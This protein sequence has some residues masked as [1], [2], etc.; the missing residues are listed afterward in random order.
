MM[1]PYRW[2]AILLIV[3]AGCS[4]T[5]QADMQRR[6]WSFNADPDATILREMIHAR[7]NDTTRDAADPSRSVGDRSRAS[8][9]YYLRDVEPIWAWLLI[10][11]PEELVEAIEKLG[12]EFAPA[13]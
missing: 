2:L 8:L 11:T 5:R 7:L 9:N 3:G 12:W 1:K 10:A 6:H 4:A 13:P